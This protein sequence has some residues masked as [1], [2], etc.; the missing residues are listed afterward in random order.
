[1]YVLFESH[2]LWSVASSVCR[3]QPVLATR[4]KQLKMW[5][6]FVAAFQRHHRKSVVR[7]VDDA[8]SPLFFNEKIDRM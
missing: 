3:L 1:M 4:K 8:K 6:E 5:V 7:V 2:V